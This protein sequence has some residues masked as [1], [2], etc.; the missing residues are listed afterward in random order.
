MY[1]G[2]P[3]TQALELGQ[4]VSFLRA[5][6]KYE[7]REA[8]TRVFIDTAITPILL[9]LGMQVRLEEPLYKHKDKKNSTLLIS[10]VRFWALSKPRMEDT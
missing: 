1:L 7:F 2:M 9:P 10:K 5:M 8:T 3:V 4:D 6:Q